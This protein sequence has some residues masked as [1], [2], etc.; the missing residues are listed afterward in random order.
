MPVLEDS[1]TKKSKKSKKSKKGLRY[2]TVFADAPSCSKVM[3][4]GVIS[5]SYPNRFETQE[6]IARSV[7]TICEGREILISSIVEL[8]KEDYE[9]YWRK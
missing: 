8:S 9:A 1:K 7:S 4:Y 5:E 3:E 2:F 6:A